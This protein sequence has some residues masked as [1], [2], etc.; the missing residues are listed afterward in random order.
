MGPKLAVTDFGTARVT[1]Q[2]L[3]EPVQSPL[4]E[5]KELPVVAASVNVT[6]LFWGKFAV[7]VPG[8]LIPPGLLVTLPGPLMAT[9]SAM[10]L[11]LKVAVTEAVAFTVMLHVAVLPLHD[12]P[13]DANV[14]P[15]AG[16]AVSVTAV[17]W[18]KVAVQVVGQLM[19]AGALT[20]VPEPEVTPVMVT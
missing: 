10:G 11:E 3:A 17:P 7:Q 5:S 6:E 1:I 12:P 18:L 9:V 8:Q 16:V 14:Y 2:V 20:T 19:P 15:A 13:Q 4:Q